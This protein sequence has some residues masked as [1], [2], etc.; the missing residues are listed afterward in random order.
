M[1]VS[2]LLAVWQETAIA[3]GW[4]GGRLLAEICAE[5]RMSHVAVMDVVRRLQLPER[6]PTT[7]RLVPEPTPENA[8]SLRGGNL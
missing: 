4:L 7:R 2:P 6:H 1:L 3:D 8:E 5:T